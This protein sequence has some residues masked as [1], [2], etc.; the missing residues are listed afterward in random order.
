MDVN[1]ST[2]EW[3]AN[4][5]HAEKFGFRGKFAYKVY[6]DGNLHQLVAKDPLKGSATIKATIKKYSVKKWEIGFGLLTETRRNQKC[7]GGW[8]D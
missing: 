1:Q 2:I 4:T 8:D 7:S 6:G 5:P 3:D